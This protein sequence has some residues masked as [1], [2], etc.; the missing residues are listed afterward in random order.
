MEEERQARLLSGQSSEVPPHCL[1]RGGKS[2]RV[3]VCVCLA[4]GQERSSCVRPVYRGLFNRVSR[5]GSGLVDSGRRGA[6]FRQ[7]VD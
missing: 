7:V 3:C 4:G 6:A 5:D 2:R 1:W